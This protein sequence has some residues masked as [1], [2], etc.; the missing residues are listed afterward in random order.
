MV[1]ERR[2]MSHNKEIELTSPNDN[3]SQMYMALTGDGDD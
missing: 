1:L 2:K 3:L